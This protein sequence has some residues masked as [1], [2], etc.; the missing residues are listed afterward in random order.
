MDLCRIVRHYF[1]LTVR[2]LSLLHVIFIIIIQVRTTH[3]RR[4]IVRP[5]QGIVAPNSSETV[6][7][8]LDEKYRQKLLTYCEERM[9]TSN[10]NKPM[11]VLAIFCQIQLAKQVKKAHDECAAKVGL[12]P[13]SVLVSEGP[14]TV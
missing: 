2:F 9:G 5:K 1:S 10:S 12:W 14:V 6:S 11:R 8:V 13:E 7:I 3:P 4:Y